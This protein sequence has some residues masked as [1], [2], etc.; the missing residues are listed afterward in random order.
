MILMIAFTH[1]E[2]DVPVVGVPET[3]INTPVLSEC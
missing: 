2:F 1:C 3:T